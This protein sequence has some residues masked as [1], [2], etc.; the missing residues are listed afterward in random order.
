[1]SVRLV[2]PPRVSA[3]DTSPAGMPAAANDDHMGDPCLWF[4]STVHDYL[5]VGGIVLLLLL[6]AVLLAVCGTEPRDSWF[7]LW[8]IAK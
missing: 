3:G 1:M 8:G 7:A 2:H 6:A 5:I 4:P